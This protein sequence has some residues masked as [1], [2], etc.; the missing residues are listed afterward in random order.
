ME[1]IRDVRVESGTSNFTDAIKPGLTVID[2]AL[3]SA[4]GP[5][6]ADLQAHSG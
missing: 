6:K 3:S 5:R 1:W 2:A 4:T